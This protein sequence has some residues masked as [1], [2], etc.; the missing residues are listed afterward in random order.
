MRQA[1]DL[2]REIKEWGISVIYSSPIERT[3]QTAEILNAYV[4]ADL[5]IEPDLIEMDLGPWQGLSKQEVA[6]Q[7]SAD[8]QLW[9]N[10]PAV[11]HLE[12]IETLQQVQERVLRCFRKFQHSKS[13]R[14]GLAVTHAVAIKCAVLHYKDLPLELYHQVAVPNLSVHKLTFNDDGGTIK[15][16]KKS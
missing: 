14:V 4:E 15:K 9:Y 8:Y 12:G 11:F 13:R 6:D 5:V 16:I 3:L 7:F 10:K 2:G 1:H